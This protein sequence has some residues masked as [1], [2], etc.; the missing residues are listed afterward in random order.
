[1]RADL[2]TE[3]NF[4]FPK[5]CF[6]TFCVRKPFFYA[7]QRPRLYLIPFLKDSSDVATVYQ[8]SQITQYNYQPSYSFRGVKKFMLQFY[9]LKWIYSSLI[10]YIHM[11][12]S[13]TPPQT[14]YYRPPTPQPPPP[15]RQQMPSFAQQVSLLVSCSLCFCTL[16]HL[17]RVASLNMGRGLSTWARATHQRLHHWGIW[18]PLP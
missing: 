9:G 2:W 8:N 12:F 14:P 4:Y 3:L 13:H 6:L 7:T 10:S 1:M 18:F 5:D 17:I 11:C 16:L 15:P